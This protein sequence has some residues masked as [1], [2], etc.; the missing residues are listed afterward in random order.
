MELFGWARFARGVGDQGSGFHVMRNVQVFKVMSII[1]LIAVVVQN[2]DLQVQGF[3][4]QLVVL[5]RELEP[6]SMSRRF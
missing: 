6:F 3:A 2:N 1:N 4:I 5:P